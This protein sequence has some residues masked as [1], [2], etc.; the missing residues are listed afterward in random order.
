MK[1]KST[2]DCVL[3][4][5]KHGHLVRIQEEVDPLSGCQFRRFVLPPDPIRSSALLRLA[6]QGF[7]FFEFFCYVHSV[8][9]SAT[10]YHK[11]ART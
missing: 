7:Q 9:G 2:R 1:Y 6:V 11:P 10:V 8:A 5:E 4:L 3:D